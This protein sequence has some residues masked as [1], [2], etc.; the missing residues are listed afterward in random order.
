MAD[1]PPP[2]VLMGAAPVTTAGLLALFAL[3][4][5]VFQIGEHLCFY[6]EPLFQ[7]FIVRII[8]MVPVYA[9]LAFCSLNDWRNS[10]YFD[11]VRDCYESW[12]IYNFLSLCLAYLGGPGAV[13]VNSEGVVVLP[14]WLTCTVCVL[15]KGGVPVNATFLRRCKQGVLQFVIVKPIVAILVLTMEAF[16]RYGDG[17]LF[18]FDKGYPYVGVFIYNLSYT[19]ALYSLLLFYLGTHE[20]LAPFKPLLKFVLIKSVIF[21]TF[22]QGLLV[23]IFVNIGTIHTPTDAKRIQN[24]LICIEMALAAVFMRVAFPAREYNP[25][26]AGGRGQGLSM[27]D[28]NAASG[29]GH[30]VSSWSVGHLGIGRVQHALSLRDV[31]NDTV[32]QFAPQYHDYCLYDASGGGMADGPDES[33]RPSLDY[34]TPVSSNGPPSSGSGNSGFWESFW[35]SAGPG[36]MPSARGGRR[37]VR[38][39]TYTLKGMPTTLSGA[40]VGTDEYARER[41]RLMLDSGPTDMPMHDTPPQGSTPDPA[42]SAPAPLT[43]STDAPVV[44]AVTEP[45]APASSSV[46]AA[47]MAVTE[48]EAPASSVPVAVVAVAE[49]QAPPPP[50]PAPSLAP[51]V[52]AAAPLPGPAPPPMPAHGPPASDQ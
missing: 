16:G 17:E 26:A 22:W 49:P 6:T 40:M 13:V 5:S 4:V 29:G 35:G 18:A 34:A 41:G 8:F 45:E 11:T 14:S 38:L 33:S 37:R 15:P 42:E 9:V 44:L 20:L 51:S 24:F 12:V 46:P 36:G 43:A 19:V 50:E 3:A 28:G 27:Q 1:A 32:H 2:A 10:L 48:P 7:R 23:T 30:D 25:A 39:K 47:L 52:P 31:V 21:L